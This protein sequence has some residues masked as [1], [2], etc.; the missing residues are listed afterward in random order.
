K[1]TRSGLIE[2]RTSSAMRALLTTGQRLIPMVVGMP[3]DEAAARAL[4]AMWQTKGRG[5]ALIAEAPAGSAAYRSSLSAI[6]VFLHRLPNGQLTAPQ[7]QELNRLIA[8]ATASAPSEPSHPAEVAMSV[9]RV[10]QLLPAG[11]AILE[12]VRYP[13]FDLRLPFGIKIRPTWR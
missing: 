8:V 10:Q 4:E 1:V 12:F 13:A 5:L 3:G 2:N 11:A 6:A 7:W 9:T